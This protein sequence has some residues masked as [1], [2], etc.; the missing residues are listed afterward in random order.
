MVPL[1]GEGGGDLQGFEE[2]CL[3]NG[4]SQGQ[5]LAVA[6][7]IVPNSP[8]SAAIITPSRCL[9]AGKSLRGPLCGP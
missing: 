4:S 1:P 7:L 8:D 6:V 3:L 9:A 5:N 2:F